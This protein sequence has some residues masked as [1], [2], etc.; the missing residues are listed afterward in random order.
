MT[1][2]KS[3]VRFSLRE[4]ALFVVIVGLA[5]S[6]ALDHQRLQGQLRYTGNPLDL[7]IEGDGFLCL[8]D[9]KTSSA[10]YTRRGELCTNANDLLVMRL[11]GIEWPV[12]PAIQIPTDATAIA[13]TPGGLV[14][15]QMPYSIAE[16]PDSRGRIVRT[17]NML[18]MGNLQLASFSQATK[19][20]QVA[21]GIFADTKESGPPEIANPGTC[22]AGLVRQGM[23]DRREN[24]KFS[25]NPWR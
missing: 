5:L 23:L 1:T 14:L 9:E 19:L 7:A 4:L 8:T 25:L 11:A 22:G 18:P 3:C 10:V 12:N 20:K 17:L 13:I 15:A 6:W 21:Q 2:W 24:Q 16:K